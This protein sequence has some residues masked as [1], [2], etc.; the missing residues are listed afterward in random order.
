MIKENAVEIIK[1]HLDDAIAA[2]KSFEAH[3][4]GFLREGDHSEPQLLFQEQIQQ[5]GNQHGKLAARL[6]A[7]GGS[8]SGVKSFLVQ[9]LSFSA[10]PVQWAHDEEERNTQDLITAF[11]LEQGQIAMYEALATIASLIGDTETEKLARDIQ[12]EERQAAAEMWGL[13]GANARLG[14]LKVT[15][16]ESSMP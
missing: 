16:G 9:L 6:Q 8:P 11:A 4:R 1:R 10:S 15:S 14:F 7:L 3:L 2:E 13:L 12:E 5:T